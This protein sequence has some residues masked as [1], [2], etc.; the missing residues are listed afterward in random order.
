M[1][2]GDLRSTD[3]LTIGWVGEVG[4]LVSGGEALMGGVW[5]GYNPPH[6]VGGLG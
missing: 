4:E 5:G 1:E 3:G 2:R 6:K